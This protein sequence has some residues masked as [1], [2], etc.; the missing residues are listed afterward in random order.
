VVA[1][2]GTTIDEVL[3]EVCGLDGLEELWA[4]VVVELGPSLWRQFRW[5]ICACRCAREFERQGD[6]ML[7]AQ[8]GE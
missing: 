6:D 4:P 2:A 5:Y 3:V 7:L 1:E 8:L